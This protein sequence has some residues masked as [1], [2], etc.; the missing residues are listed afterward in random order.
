MYL[1][2]SKAQ[3]CCKQEDLHIEYLAQHLANS[4]W[5][6]NKVTIKQTCLP[7]YHTWGTL[8]RWL[9]LYYT[10]KK[11]NK[12]KH[13]KALKRWG[14]KR[15]D[16]NCLGFP[17]ETIPR[18]LFSLEKDGFGE[19]VYPHM[20]PELFS[21]LFF[22]VKSCKEVSSYLK[23]FRELMKRSLFPNWPLSANFL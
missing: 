13:Y 1:I 4:N 3:S 2:I 18:K 15:G 5:L 10:L 23:A 19:T 8:Q 6:G 12:W 20:P 11:R 22:Q 7:K 16:A 21:Y 9:P 14:E 17:L